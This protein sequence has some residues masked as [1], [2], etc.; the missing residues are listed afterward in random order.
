M[1]SNAK[2][3][4]C[5]VVVVVFLLFFLGVGVGVGWYF[6]NVKNTHV[7]VC[8][9][10]FDFL[11]ISVPH[12][13]YLEELCAVFY[14]LCT[15]SEELLPILHSLNIT[16]CKIYGSAYVECLIYITKNTFSKRTCGYP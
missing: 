16:K 7:H 13:R 14:Q 3:R 2:C 9:M 12:V 1:E 8:Y 4:I 11:R 10:Q 15:C 5:F 6:I